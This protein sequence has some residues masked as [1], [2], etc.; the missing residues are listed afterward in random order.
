MPATGT[1]AGTSAGPDGTGPL[2]RAAGDYLQH[3]GVERD[4]RPIRWPPTGGT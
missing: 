2:V 3:M 4:W 1:V